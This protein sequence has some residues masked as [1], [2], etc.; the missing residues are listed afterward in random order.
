[1]AKKDEIVM[2]LSASDADLWASW[3]EAP[4]QPLSEETKAR[5]VADVARVAGLPQMVINGG[6]VLP[7][8]AWWAHLVQQGE[9]AVSTAAKEAGDDR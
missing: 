7:G 6:S 9:T 8:S 3:A 4:V 1:M 2:V 5:I